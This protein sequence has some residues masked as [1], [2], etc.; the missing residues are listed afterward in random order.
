VKFLFF[1]FSCTPDVSNAAFCRVD[2]T[3]LTV[4]KKKTEPA[5]GKGPVTSPCWKKLSPLLQEISPKTNTSKRENGPPYV[6]PRR[7]G[8]FF[9][10]TP[11]GKIVEVPNTKV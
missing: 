8:C 5:I 9:A 6:T 2:P 4:Q 3:C 7:Q 10:G 11:F 1:E